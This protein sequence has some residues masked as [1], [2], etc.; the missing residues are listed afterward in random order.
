MSQ[1]DYNRGAV[2]GLLV[3]LGTAFVMIVAL[4]LLAGCTGTFDLR[5]GIVEGSAGPCIA[6]PCEPEPEETP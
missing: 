6:N 2:R 1:A 4:G 3:G 5:E